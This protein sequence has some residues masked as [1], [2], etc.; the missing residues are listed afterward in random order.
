[1][2]STSRNLLVIVGALASVGLLIAGTPA[3]GSDG[4]ST[5][6][7]PDARGPNF[8][9]DGTFGNPDSQPDGGDPF[10]N[11]PPP[12]YCG[13]NPQSAPPKPGGTVEC[14]DDKNK[15]GC[16]CDTVGEQAACW[17]GL[18]VNRHLG[19]CK[20]GVT[21]C[22]QKT[23]NT[24]AWGPCE[25]QVLPTAGETKG[26]AA[27]K[28]FSVGKWNLANL[29]PCFREYCNTTPVDGECPAAN[30][31]GFY[32]VSTVVD[33]NGVAQC[34]DQGAAPGP[35][36][37]PTE[38]WTTDTLTGDCAGHFK[39][40]YELKA[41]DFSNPQPTDCSLTKLCVEGDYL[42][43][44]VEQAFPDLPAWLS[45]NQDCAKQWNKVGGYGEMTVVGESVLCDKVD[46][47]AG[48]SFVFNRVKY[49]PSL[50]RKKD[51]NGVLINK[52]L[53]ECQNCGQ[54]GS[55]QF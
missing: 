43:E 38:R 55:G 51:V 26:S 15:P 10:A 2:P 28:C 6:G 30:V 19:V 18:R 11:D 23:E 33:A 49:C 41:G 39:L 17:T 47:G 7:D 37:M 12:N 13:P 20:D 53:P 22:E 34:T 27:C 50:C 48:N 9:T 46:D 16:G 24:K 1:M 25:G 29:S 21:K 3:C 54:G 4:D 5:F 31:S 14:P 32:A 35:G 45:P 44:N 40:C 52:D 42:K 8:E 36:P